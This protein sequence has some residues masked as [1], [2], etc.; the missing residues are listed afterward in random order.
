MMVVMMMVLLLQN[1]LRGFTTLHALTLLQRLQLGMP[2]P[3]Q[4]SVA[5]LLGTELREL[6]FTHRRKV[7]QRGIARAAARRIA[8]LH[9]LEKVLGGRRQCGTR[10][11]EHT[12]K[13]RQRKATRS[14]KHDAAV[15][16]QNQMVKQIKQVDARLMNACDARRTRRQLLD[17]AHQCQRRE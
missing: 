16:E 1:A 3:L 2:P 6:I 4:C 14:A 10:V 12:L 9:H 5:H 8:V 13:V 11:S 15:I 17:V 7:Q